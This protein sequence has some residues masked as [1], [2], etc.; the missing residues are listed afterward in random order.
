MAGGEA[1]METPEL[2]LVS[3]L[4]TSFVKNEFY[5]TEKETVDQIKQLLASLKDKRFAAQAA[6]YAR[7]EFGMRSVSHVLAGELGILPD[8]KGTPWI[9]HFY[10][11]VVFR[12][13]DISEI[14]AYFLKKYGNDVGTRPIPNAMKKGFSWAL[15]RFDNYQIAKYKM[16]SRDWSMVDLVNVLRPKPTDKNKDSLQ[17]LIAGHLTADGTWE[18]KMSQSAQLVDED[19]G[20]TV[21][22]KS[23]EEV[24]A[25]KNEAWS[26][27]VT[28][29]KIGYMA[30]LKNLRNILEAGDE[31]TINAAC[32]MLVDERLISKSL[33]L[34]FR[35]TTAYRE[36]ER[37]SGKPARAVLMAISDALD[38]A[39]KNVPVFEGNT[40]VVLDDSG[41]M[42]NLEMDAKT[43]FSIGALFAAVLVKANN[44]DF[45]MFSD[46]AR[47]IS[48]NP[49]DSVISLRSKMNEHRTGAGTNFNAIFELAK[50]KYDRIVILSDMQG[51]GPSTFGFLYNSGAP[52]KAFADYKKRTGANPHVYSF[53]LQGLGTLQFPEHQVYAIAG[54]SEK[55]FD[56]MRNLERDRN[57]MVNEIRKVWLPEK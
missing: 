44:A 22:R 31:E 6:I 16:E 55:V 14:L 49:R 34:P 4:L 47:Y 32:E 56:L 53:D 57:A 29:R 13:D 28:T 38:I 54:F 2:A 39:C 35:F 3:L 46:R 37:L 51:W 25:A 11:K 15:R 5:R 27:L 8:A 33:V 42:G 7:T 36:I 23:D 17:K 26:E 48:L 10:N 30:L 12:P 21:G 1:Y 9:R 52:T 50:D 45:M 24:V 19:T 18:T 20:E 40:L 43:P 41:S